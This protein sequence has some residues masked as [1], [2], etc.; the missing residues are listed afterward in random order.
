MPRQDFPGCEY[1]L[2]Q[3]ERNQQLKLTQKSRA[4]RN[5]DEQLPRAR[6]WKQLGFGNHVTPH[7]NT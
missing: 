4:V 7:H 6:S 3:H 1:F 2:K 5:F